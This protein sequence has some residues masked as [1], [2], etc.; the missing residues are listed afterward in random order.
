M[1]S[2]AFDT[3]V[4][5]S[6]SEQGHK[7]GLNFVQFAEKLYPGLNQQDIMSEARAKYMTALAKNQIPRGRTAGKVGNL[8]DKIVSFLTAGIEAGREAEMQDM[9]SIFNKFRSGE[10]GRRGPPVP[11][12]PRSLRLSKYADPRH[13]AALKKAI[14]EGD[15]DAEQRIAQDIL[16]E[17][18]FD[19][20]QSAPPELTWRDRLF[21]QF[22]MD[23]ELANT[24]PGEIPLIGINASDRA[25][26]EYFRQKRGEQPYTMPEA[27]KHK[28]RNQERWA[29]SKE[30][31]DLVGDRA[32]RMKTEPKLSSEISIDAMSELDALAALTSDPRWPSWTKEEQF[33]RT[34]EVLGSFAVTWSN[35]FWPKIK[36]IWRRNI[37]DGAY[38]VEKQGQMKDR[39]TTGLRSLSDSSAVSMV[40]WRNSIGNPMTSVWRLGGISWIGDPLDGTHTFQ[41]Y[42]PEQKTLEQMAALLQ[43]PQDRTY[44]GLHIGALR[45]LALNRKRLNGE[46]QAELVRAKEANNEANT[47]FFKQQVIKRPWDS[48]LSNE[49]QVAAAQEMV[50]RIEVEAPHVVEAMKAYE[51]HN[52]GSSLPWLLDTGWITQEMYDYLQDI[53]YVPIYKDVGTA[54]SWPLGSNGRSRRLEVGRMVQKEGSV[55]EH[56]LESFDGLEDI[57]LLANILNSEIA[58][59]R[60]GFSNLAA[61]RVVRDAQQLTEQGYGVQSKQVDEAGPNVLRIMV[62]GQQEFHELADPLLANAVMT[63]GFSGTNNFLRAARIGAQVT[64]WGVVN[65]PLFIYNNFARDARGVNSINAAAKPS[66]VPL[67]DSIRRVMEGDVLQKSLE[68][69]LI[70]GSGLY[71]SV[72]EQIGGMTAFQELLEGESA[73]AKSLRKMGF[74]TAGERIASAAGMQQR[75]EEMSAEIKEGRMPLKNIR[76]YYA[77][78]R[79]MYRNLQEIGESTARLGAHDTVLAATGSMAEAMHSGHETLNFGRHGDN[80]Y[81]NAVTSM[82]PFMSGMIT[83]TDT[84]IRSWTGSPDAIGKHAVDPR[85]NDEAANALKFRALNRSLFALASFFV[86]YMMIRDDEHYKSIGEV[87]K[88]N[89][90]LIPVGDKYFKVPTSFATGA[91][92]KTIPEALLRTIDEDDYTAADVGK[93][94]VDQVKRNLGF[95]IMPQV[96]RPM[97]DAMRNRNDF[98]REPIVP[99]YMADL[100]SEYQKTPYTSDSAELLANMFGKLPGV[101]TLSSP[102]KMEYMIRQYFG[103][104]GLYAMLI[105]DRIARE[106]TGKNIV[107]T[108]YD[109][110][111]SSLLTGEGLENVPIIGDFIGDWRTGRGNVD[112][113]Y[114]LKD[115]VD[116]YMTVLNKLAREGSPEEVQKWIEDNI[117][118]HNYRNK[119]RSFGTYMNKWRE[120]RNKLLRSDWMSDDRKRELLF[121]MIEERDEVLDNLTSVKAGMKGLMPYNRERSVI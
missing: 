74:K 43:S 16:D 6:V 11:G 41:K 64:R 54:A 120:R 119:V 12:Q 87:E 39:V 21:N 4:P 113:F 35:G 36:D 58:M 109:W 46:A 90:F 59:L 32:S 20:A 68:A 103:Q 76:D 49:E 9:L 82:I 8:K 106:Y 94:A 95:H 62:N 57:D 55:F 93:E 30:L 104:A 10:V 50:D 81:V 31:E 96:M 5:A 1:D 85:M 101:D 65:F 84:L 70:T 77:Y 26:N 52:K 18:K 48:N 23:E 83:G 38:P 45:F 56:A 71:P 22:M 73:L 72:Q 42:G 116:I 117:D 33:K 7:D 79:V 27:I 112:K 80:P 28:F 67:I 89:N 19:M 51:A 78:M 47:G 98:T 66:F 92:L 99:S 3:V 115:E 100:P 37:A 25:I 69:G 29:P 60:D 75:Y 105:S 97:W 44:A 110:A 108:R 34:N 40:R 121:K 2:R 88:M 53:P 111:P 86:Y 91:L 102:M 118:T 114:E 13:I 24:R 63:M 15:T 107:G 61:R 17:K 14:E